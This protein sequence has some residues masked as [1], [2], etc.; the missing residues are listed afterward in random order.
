MA[1]LSFYLILAV[2]LIL[3]TMFVLFNKASM[4]GLAVK[5]LAPLS[6][7]MLALVAANLSSSFGGYTLFVC[8]GLGIIIAV[9]TYAA[10]QKENQNYTFLSGLN[11]VAVLAFVVAG[12]LLAQIN[13]FALGLGALLGTSVACVVMIFKKLSRL[14]STFV[15]L[16]I[17]AAFAMLGQGVALLMSGMLLPAIIFTVS[18]VL[19][20]SHLLLKLFGSGKV[21][22]IIT[23]VLRILSLVAIATSIYFL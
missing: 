9:E 22:L 11:L 13:V 3:G 5:S 20:F 2:T 23:N 21:C 1:A 14:Q 18:A 8:L 16:N 7:L 12:V 4:L 19:T 15:C 6:C 17:I 10:A